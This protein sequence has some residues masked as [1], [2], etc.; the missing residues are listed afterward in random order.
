[1]SNDTDMLTGIFFVTRAVILLATM[2]GLI[3]FFYMVVIDIYPNIEPVSFALYLIFICIYCYVLIIKHL[4]DNTF[5]IKWCSIKLCLYFGIP[6]ILYNQILMVG[7][8]YMSDVLLNIMRNISS[9]WYNIVGSIAVIVSIIKIIS[10]YVSI[11]NDSNLLGINER[12]IKFN[13]RDVLTVSLKPLIPL[14]LCFI[15]PI[16][17][18]IMFFIGMYDEATIYYANIGLAFIFTFLC[19]F[20]SI[21]SGNVFIVDLIGYN[22]FDNKKVKQKK[23]IVWISIYIIISLLVSFAYS[24]VLF[25]V[26][27]IDI[28]GLAITFTVIYMIIII[29]I[30]MFGCIKGFTMGYFNNRKINIFTVIKMNEIKYLLTHK[31][32]DN[33]WIMFPCECNEAEKIIKIVKGK[34][35]ISEINKGNIEEIKGYAL[36]VHNETMKI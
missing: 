19:V 15:L 30:C 11:K 13:V 7:V 28:Q 10:E 20:I 4:D 31:Y 3:M 36:K 9:N 35:A 6:V 21:I 25:P 12:M 33:M 24:H 17:L 8:D 18:I 32:N 34:Y 22:I 29:I 23:S 1:M 27:G 14:F 2:A 26:V 16:I 5:G